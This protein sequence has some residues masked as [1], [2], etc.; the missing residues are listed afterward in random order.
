MPSLYRA[1]NTNI[2]NK[3]RGGK[4]NSP[5]KKKI[6][7]KTCKNSL[8]EVECFLKDFNKFIKYVKLYKILK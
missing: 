4:K 3:N 1:E 8:T 2:S 5:P 6:S 7:F